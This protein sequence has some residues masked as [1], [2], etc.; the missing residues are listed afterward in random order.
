M[1]HD[2]TGVDAEAGRVRA[3]RDGGKMPS[4]HPGSGARTHRHSFVKAAFNKVFGYFL[5]ITTRTRISSPSTISAASTHRCRALRHPRASR[6]REKVLTAA[7]RIETRERW[8]CST[9]SVHRGDVTSDRPVCARIAAE[10]D[11]LASLSGVAAR[12][13]YAG[14]CSRADSI[15]TS[16][17]SS[18]VVEA[19]DG[20]QVHPND[21]QLVSDGPAHHLT[22]RTCRQEHDPAAVGLIVLMRR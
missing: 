20:R 1:R 15:S 11:V 9:H 14:P 12:E 17:W 2:A 16:P 3:L 13:G 8:P 10:L 5:E 6:I 7:E 21:V 4:P 18:S 22:G 19:H